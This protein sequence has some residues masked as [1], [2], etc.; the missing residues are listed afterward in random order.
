MTS[1]EFDTST[2]NSVTTWWTRYLYVVLSSGLPSVT[3][4]IYCRRRERATVSRA[5]SM[6]ELSFGA[7]RSAEVVNIGGPFFAVVVASRDRLRRKGEIES[8][9]RLVVARSATRHATFA[10]EIIGLRR[11]VRDVSRVSE[12][13]SGME[14]FDDKTVRV[15]IRRKNSSAAHTERASRVSTCVSRLFDR[16]IRAR[17]FAREGVA[18]TN[19]RRLWVLRRWRMFLF[20]IFHRDEGKV[21]FFSLHSSVSEAPFVETLRLACFAFTREPISKL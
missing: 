1:M 10:R 17:S 19:E 16:P 9:W 8:T 11:L 2:N 20:E 13:A 6:F 4:A 21:T 7:T 14:N 12:R 5:A 18:T 15:A 3:S